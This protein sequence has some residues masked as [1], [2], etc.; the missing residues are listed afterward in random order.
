MPRGL[1]RIHPRAVHEGNQVGSHRGQEVAR[2]MQAGPMRLE[3]P[4]DALLLGL[5]DPNPSA[6]LVSQ[7]RLNRAPERVGVVGRT[8]F[9]EVVGPEDPR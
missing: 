3:A 2:N 5:L 8:R 4:C 1:G 7:Q 6:C 9:D